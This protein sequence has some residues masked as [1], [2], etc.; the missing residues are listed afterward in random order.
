MTASRHHVR[1]ALLN[2]K[3]PFE[4]RY[5]FPYPGSGMGRS[6]TAF[7]NA[8]TLSLLMCSWCSTTSRIWANSE[9]ELL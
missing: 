9:N 4:R 8:K 1:N 6:A 5:A 7:K 2:Q 3:L